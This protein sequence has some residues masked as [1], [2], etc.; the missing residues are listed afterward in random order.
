MS[1]FQYYE[2]YSVD[3]ELTHQEREEVDSLSSRFSPTSRRAV[4]SYSYSSFRHDEESVLLK[5]FDFF[6]YLSNWG[7][8]RVMYKFPEDLVD[9]DKLKKYICSVDNYFADNGI[10]I[11][12]KSKYVL[13]DINL[14]EEGGGFWIE[15]ENYLS[16]DLIGIR[17][18]ILQGDYR[19]LFIMWLHMKKIEL[20]IEQIDDSMEI[21]IHLI[22][23]NLGK[24]NRKLESLMRLYEVDVDWVKG[25][26]NYSNTSKNKARDYKEFI[27]NL[28]AE[29][30]DDYLLKILSG[31]PNLKIKL[32]KDLDK[33]NGKKE[34]EVEGKIT[35]EQLLNSVKED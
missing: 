19:A 4:F 9:H 7:T 2:F 31:E 26:S 14:S 8:K 29:K 34:R 5:Y 24:L 25:A 22:P 33:I 30:K 6:L 17:E 13:I 3:R 21:P 18:D 10:R 1:E 27:E 35:I 12:K 16:S 32:Q 20:E 15:D 11:F 23:E 28:S